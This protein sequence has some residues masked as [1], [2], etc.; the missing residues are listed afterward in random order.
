MAIC[1]LEYIVS[2]TP[3]NERLEQQ[4]KWNSI[5]IRKIEIT[6]IIIVIVIII[7]MTIMMIIIVAV[8]RNNVT[9]TTTKA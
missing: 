1:G 9:T 2:T 5:A 8:K 4:K 6:I 3:H 7:M